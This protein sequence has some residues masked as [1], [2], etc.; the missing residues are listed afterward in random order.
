MP[1]ASTRGSSAWLDDG[2]ELQPVDQLSRCLIVAERI[3]AT[4]EDGKA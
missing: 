1:L 4:N 3:G 2:S